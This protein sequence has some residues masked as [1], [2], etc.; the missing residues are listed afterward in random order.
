MGAPDSP[1]RHR[2]GTVPCPV[3]R[4]VTQP[5]GFGAGSIVGALSSCD[6]GQSGASDFVALT[7]AHHC[8]V[9][10]ICAESTIGADSRAPLAHRTVRWHTGQS[11]EL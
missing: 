3:H 1:V 9:L 10:F 5:L 4:H 6:I 7:S 11:G 8:S 2:T